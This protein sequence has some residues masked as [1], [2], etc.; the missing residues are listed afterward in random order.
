MPDDQD[1]CR[2]GQLIGEAGQRIEHVVSA[3]DGGR[4]ARTAH[5]REVGVDAPETTVRSEDGVEA[6]FGLAMVDTSAVK[7]HHGYALAVLDVMDGD[8]SD[9]ALHVVTV[10]T[11]RCAPEAV[12]G[13]SERSR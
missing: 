13:R 7:H 4:S 5:S 3:T 8:V 6:S 1:W 12:G 10:A 9:P 11:F 2:T